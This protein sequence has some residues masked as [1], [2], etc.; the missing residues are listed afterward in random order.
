MKLILK[1]IKP[2]IALVII[3]LIFLFGQAV[4][5]LSLPNLMSDIV[6]VGIQNS[7]IEEKIPYEISENGMKLLSFFMPDEDAEFMVSGYTLEN[8]VYKIKETD[9]DNIERMGEIYG[10]SALAFIGYMNSLQGSTDEN[11][12]DEEALTDYE[13]IDVKDFYALIPMLE[14]LP[15]GSLD[16]Y[17]V[18]AENSDG[19]LLEQIGVVFT[20]LFY[21]ETGR[22]VAEMQQS[23]IL[24]KGA[25]MLAVA[26][27]GVIAAVI[28]GFMAAKIGSGVAR[29]IRKDVF[30][31]VE[32]FSNGEFD[33]FSTA[34]LITRTT[35]DVQQVQMLVTMGLR[36][37][38]YAPII[39]IGGVFMAVNKSVSLSWLI[40]VAVII[41]LG[42]ILVVFSIAIP[43][44]KSLQK[45]I[46]RINLV[47]R[48]NLSGMMVIR[49]FGNEKY[50]EKRFE[51]ANSELSNTNRFIQ[52]V[53]AFMMPAMTLIMNMLSLGIVWVGSHAIAES[54]LQIGDMMAFIQYAMQIIMAFLMIAM[55]FIM[56][57]R[58]S[59]SA[60]RIEEVLDTELMIKEP[61]N[62]SE[63]YAVDTNRITVEF[64]DVSFKYVNAENNVLE[65]ISLKAEPGKTTAFIG[66]TGSG[67]S[68]IINLIPRFYDVTEGSIEFNGVDIRNIPQED[69]RNAIGYVPQKGVLFSG[70]IKSNLSYGKNDAS[71]QEI[72]EAIDVAQAREFVDSTEEGIGTPIAQGGGNVSG[73]Q[74]QRLAIARALVKKPPVYIFDDSFSALDFK[75]DAALRKALKKYTKDATVFIVA[76]RVSTIMNAEQIVVLDKGKIVG[77][78]TH[79]ELMDTCGTY[80]E[81]AESQLA[82]EE[83][84]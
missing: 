61:E 32:S 73:G 68:T 37:M 40:A 4:T 45:L 3:S 1:Y 15:E 63:K 11:A 77:I 12:A 58:A 18:S 71:D 48:E 21:E 64:K 41:L 34:S 27:A 75:T 51:K 20:K 39:G 49:A 9:S 81:I 69:L 28:V 29:N 54:T 8:G 67:K 52:R 16:S 17:I 84:Q 36:L 65:H 47:S 57:P 7:G 26:L 6:N 53:M 24:K 50:E 55:M 46:D 35:N 38:C 5:D 79:K 33:K 60:M 44:F 14:A 2:F 19:M 76:Q 42:L 62:G 70:D 72:Y 25:V 10:R 43:K 66:S 83:L 31:K 13:D 80:R 30:E 56:V 23:Y 74:K 59:V 22:D 78:G 82:K